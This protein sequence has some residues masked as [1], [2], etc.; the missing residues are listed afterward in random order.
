MVRALDDGVI[1]EQTSV[2]DYG[3]G[4]GGDVRRLKSMGVDATG[5][6]PA[7]AP[8]Q[9]LRPADVVNLGFVVNV[10]EDPQ[11]R[12]LTLTGAWKLAGE[13][14]V[15][16]ARLDWEARELG[17]VRHADGVLTGTGTFQK[18]YTQEGLRAWI[19][20]T[21]GVKSV[22]A[23]P[24]IFY[25]FRRPEIAQRVLAHRTRVGN[26]GQ[27]VAQLLYERHA[28]LLEPIAAFASK[29]AALPNATDIPDAEGVI[30]AFG[31]IRNAFMLIRR[32]DG[33][34]KWR[35]VHLPPGRQSERRFEQNL[36]LLAPLIDFLEQRGRLPRSDELANT[37]ELESEFGSARGA[38]SL[39]RRVTGPSQ[40]EAFEHRA[41]QNALVFVA[42][43]A[44]GGRPRFGE[45]PEDLKYD[46]KD[47]FG[48]YKNACSEADELLFAVGDPD[49][50]G[51]AFESAPFGKLTPEA[52][53]V[54]VRGLHLLPP[55]LRVYEGCARTLTGDIEGATI[56]KMHKLKP[57]V[58]YLLYPTFDKDPHPALLGSVVSRLAR[59]HVDYRSFRDSENPPILHRK[60]AFV[61]TS[62]PGREKFARLTRQ[63][64]K[65]ELLGRPDI[66]T[67]RGWEDLLASRRLK[68]RGHRVSRT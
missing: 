28:D 59:L 3:C 20:S 29:N 50:L 56:L 9:P 48:S 19:D 60:E 43:S 32:A 17:G 10:I 5:W 44:F 22:A 65:Y 34:T 35:K 6:D 62:Y 36:S 57:Q 47:F 68:L 38:F 23:A 54:H 41:R 37:E 13:T 7:F 14:L 66:G 18:F 31:S 51:E 61:P 1:K 25:V 24:G 58:S 52:L 39:I 11:E 53:Y 64:E 63:E 8:D 33:P 27:T 55:I 42:L 45:L 67:L 15:V 49:R 12:A 46:V 21:L 26:G 16:A 40:W 30:K 2:F 4:R